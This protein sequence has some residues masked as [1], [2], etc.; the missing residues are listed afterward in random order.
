MEETK[1]EKLARLSG[2]ATSKALDALRK[3]G[4][5]I[6]GKL[7]TPIS[8][9]PRQAP[10]PKPDRANEADPKTIYNWRRLDDFPARRSRTISTT[11]EWSRAKRYE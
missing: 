2:K 6:R 3:R 1:L 7:S 11:L 4:F 10:Q 8:R 9:V 5:D